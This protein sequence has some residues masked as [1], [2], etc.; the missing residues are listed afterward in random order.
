MHWKAAILLTA[1]VG[2]LFSTGCSAF[3]SHSEKPAQLRPLRIGVRGTMA[4]SNEIGA[5]TYS[6]TFQVQTLLYETLVKRDANGRLTAGLASSWDFEDGGRTLILTLRSGAVWHDGTPVTADDVR[7]HFKRWLGL[8]E[9]AW[10]HSSERVQQV[11]AEGTNRVRITLSEPYALLPDLCAIRPCAIGGPGCLDRQGEWVQPV[12]SGP[13]RF[14]EL[15]ERGRVYRLARVRPTGHSVLARDTID[16]VPFD[17]V[18]TDENEPFELFR[19]GGLDVL[20][21]GWKSRIPREQVAWLKRQPGLTVQ[22][23]PGSVLHY[24]SFRLEGPT[25]DEILRKH[26]ATALDKAELIRVVEGGFADR[27]DSWTAPTVKTWPQIPIPKPT[28]PLP[29][30]AQPLRLLGYQD[31]FRPREQQWC[32]TVAAQL[33]RAGIPVVMQLKGGDEYKQAVAKGDY[34]LR[35]EITWGVPYDPDM[36]LKARFLPPPFTR[37]TGAG[38]RYFGVDPRAEALTR[39]IAATPDE[40]DR[41]PLYAQM[42]RLLS[43]EALVVPLYVPRRIAVIRRQDIHLPLD[44]DVYRDAL[45]ALTDQP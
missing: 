44:H 16:V 26:I 6:S 1:G 39:Q 17:A 41:L 35:T 21:D 32:D 2:F 31:H 30:L 22:E 23:A 9:F 5:L 18:H 25:A 45:T 15:R 3:F 43:E 28:A 24:L 14:V 11:V 13:F 20:I 34:D 38:N 8:P 4:F 19:Q 40:R 42:Q 29:K 27:T 7:I 10:I 12:G 33:R 36:S 37:P